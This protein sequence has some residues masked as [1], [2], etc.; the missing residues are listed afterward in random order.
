MDPK[1]SA[2]LA[3]DWNLVEA[4]PADRMSV[5]AQSFGEFLLPRVERFIR[6]LAPIVRGP[7]DAESTIR[8]PRREAPQTPGSQLIAGVQTGRVLQPMGFR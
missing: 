2:A 4:E 8:D 5:G 7:P 6:R 1:A 3:H